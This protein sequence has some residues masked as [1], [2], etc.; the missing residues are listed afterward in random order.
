V[1]EYFGVEPT[2]LTIDV[3]TCEVYEFKAG[4]VSTTWTHGNLTTLF[5]QIDRSSTPDRAR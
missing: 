3:R 2:G 1:A 4:R 5:H